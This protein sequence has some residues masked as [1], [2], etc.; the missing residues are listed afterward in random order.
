MC[1]I[2]DDLEGQGVD[3]KTQLHLHLM[4]QAAKEGLLSPTD[5]GTILHSE[6]QNVP[7]DWFKN[8]MV[9]RATEIFDAEGQ[10]GLDQWAKQV[11]LEPSTLRLWMQER[12]EA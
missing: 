11:G 3:A 7:P 1:T 2:C 12:Q 10:V 8:A 4:F 6:T 5:T 9:Q